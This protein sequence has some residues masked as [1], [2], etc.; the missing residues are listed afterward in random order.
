MIM[1]YLHSDKVTR[2]HL[3]DHTK[4]NDGQDSSNFREKYCFM[5]LE[6]DKIVLPRVV[7]RGFR[8]RDLEI[9]PNSTVSFGR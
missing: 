3:T 8:K 6:P 5:D 1:T 9:F 2:N 7:S 4:I